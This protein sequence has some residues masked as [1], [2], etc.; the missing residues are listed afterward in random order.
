MDKAA[1]VGLDIER[2]REVLDALDTAGIK[3][4]A[5]L[6]V[7]LPEYED[8]RLVLAARQF[9]NL[10]L[11]DAYRKAHDALDAG[12]I[13]VYKTPPLM[14]LPVTDPLIKGLRRIFSKAASVEGMRP[15][16]QMIGDRFIEDAYVYRIS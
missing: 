1:L 4:A 10:A 15:G 12:G 3:V 13:T 6:W 2:G 9:D 11:R 14:I 7:Y 16:G 8:W 5:A